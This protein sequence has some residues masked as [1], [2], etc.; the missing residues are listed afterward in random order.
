M[1]SVAPRHQSVLPRKKAGNPGQWMPHRSSFSAAVRVADRLP[2]PYTYGP[3][4]T[5]V[6]ARPRKRPPKPA[7]AA[8]I[9][10]PRI[11]QHTPRGRAWKLPPD[12]PEAKARA[13][14]FLSRMIRPREGT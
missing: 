6:T 2:G 4:M 8:M 5:I 10:V 9:K 14:A 7:Q 12:D 1:E 3:T 13:V 11:V